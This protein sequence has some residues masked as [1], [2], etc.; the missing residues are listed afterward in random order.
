MVNSEDIQEIGQIEKFGNSESLDEIV[1]GKEKYET[2]TKEE[3]K[4]R[5][6]K[7]DAKAQKF[8]VSRVDSTLAHYEM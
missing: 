5:W 8:L 1:T 6:L 2:L 3:D 4:K 7:N